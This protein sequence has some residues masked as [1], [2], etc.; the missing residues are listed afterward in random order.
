NDVFRESWQE[1]GIERKA[2]EPPPSM[3]PNAN[4]ASRSP[5]AGGSSSNGKLPGTGDQETLVK[6]ITD[7]VMAVLSQSGK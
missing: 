3:R 7:R 4:P 5:A 6:T 1:C 2:F